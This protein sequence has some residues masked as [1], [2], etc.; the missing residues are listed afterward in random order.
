MKTAFEKYHGGVNMRIDSLKSRFISF[1]LTL[2]MFISIIAFTAVPA[3]AAS[4]ITFNTLDEIKEDLQ[5]FK[6]ITGGTI[7]AVKMNSAWYYRFTRTGAD[8][9]YIKASAFTGTP[10]NKYL[11]EDNR[12]LSNH[13]TS[14]WE[15]ICYY[16]RQSKKIGMNY[17][18]YT[19]YM[20][21]FRLE[22][23]GMSNAKITTKCT[24][25]HFVSFSFQTKIPYALNGYTNVGSPTV[26][27]PSYVEPSTATGYVNALKR[28]ANVNPIT[29]TINLK[30]SNTG[31]N[32]IC[33][34][35]YRLCGL[36]DASL[37]VNVNDLISVGTSVKNTIVALA[38]IS[39][40]A[41]KPLVSLVSLIGNVTTMLNYD[42]QIY[43][44]GEANKLTVG[45]QNPTLEAQ[46]KSPIKLTKINDWMQ[47]D[48][49]L[50]APQTKAAFAIEF[51][52]A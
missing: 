43:N 38:G 18:T 51:S 11:E 39:K 32:K 49:Y 3:S 24:V 34:T 16:D 45:G 44:T 10:T 31:K 9:I 42:S 2:A 14:N 6:T 22:V 46:Y 47:V 33:L 13:S 20:Y 5:I 28:T 40:N 8:T 36:G 7:S 41:I 21:R 23:L 30:V 19:T 50:N 4:C 29:P 15:R 52:F 1:F 35:E 12:A 37:K 26:N 48:T 17:D 27:P 25:L